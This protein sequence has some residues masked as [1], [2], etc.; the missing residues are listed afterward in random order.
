MEM[1]LLLALVL[2]NFDLELC[3]ASKLWDKQRVY[4][5]WEKP[6]LKVKVLPRKL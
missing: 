3:P 1:R 6:E 5:L 4:N 2:W